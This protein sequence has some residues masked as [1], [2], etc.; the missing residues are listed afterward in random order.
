M[1]NYP[2]IYTDSLH[3]YDPTFILPMAFM[4]L[5]YLLLQRSDH[6]FLINL[7]NNWSPITKGLLIIYASAFSIVLPQTYL[8]SWIGFGMTH[9]VV[10][11]S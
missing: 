6:P 9:L 3:L 5:N 4:S 11:E 10:K 1:S 2:S 7:R 8:V